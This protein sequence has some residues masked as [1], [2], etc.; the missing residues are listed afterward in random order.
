MPVRPTRP[1]A[2]DAHLPAPPR[3]RLRAVALVA[4]LALVAAS[5]SGAD[6]RADGDGDRPERSSGGPST[7]AP[8]TDDPGVADAPEVQDVIRVEVLSS[9]PDRVSGPDARIRITAARGGDAADLT[10][11]I[12]DRDVTDRFTPAPDGASGASI[13]G[14]V[15]GLVEGTNTLTVSDGSDSVA[16]RLRSWPLTGPMISG[17]HVPLLACSTEAHGLGQ[18]TDADCSAPTRVTWRYVTEDGD[19]ADLAGPDDRPDDLATAT[20]DGDPVP[21][22][23][24]HEVGVVNRSVYELATVDPGPGPG[25]DADGAGIASNGRLLYRFGDGCGATHGQGEATVDVLDADRL[26]AGYALATATFNTGAVQ[27]NDV[28][29]AETAMMVKERFIE[30]FG[31]PEQTIGEGTGFGAAQVHLLVQN[32]PGL[33]DGGVAVAP[34]PDVV[35]VLGGITDCA[36][37]ERWYGGPAG[38][39]LT[40]DQRTAVNGHATAATC[41]RW[42]DEYG[43]LVDPTAGCDPAIDPDEIH[44]PATGTGVRCTYQDLNANQ[45]GRDDAGRGIRPLDN[46]GIQYGLDALNAGVIDLEQFVALNEGIGGYDVDGLPQADRHEADADDLLTV[47]EN[48]RVS[49]G[50]GDQIKIPIVEIDVYDD[51][52]GDPADRVRAFSLRDRLTYGAPAESVPGFQI[53]T[54]LPAA[55]ADP[56]LEALTVVDEWLTTLGDD[57]GGGERFSVLARTR[58]EAAVDNCLPADADRPVGGV[59]VYDEDGPCAEDHPVAGDPRLAAGAPLSNDVLKCQLKPVDPADYDI[60]LA[61]SDLERLRDVFPAGVCDWGSFGVGQTVPSMPDRTYEDVETPADLA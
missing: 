59:G 22:I 48:G 24:R 53:W 61:P 34:F 54:R 56:G 38:S 3:R 11:T 44:D 23:V 4:G 42:A 6:D 30:T 29:S 14:V 43:D 8:D 32:Y 57:T 18:P 49:T 7:T 47:Y 37:L 19:V 10:V 55:P 5:C 15:G 58:P 20:I 25:D 9:Q 27:C 41:T 26:E 60:T 45:L 1:T 28:V 2:P 17:P 13:E 50:V 33:L 39:A 51:P 21:L 16:Q 52:T 36:L 35:T 12:G 31:P 46:V 40:P